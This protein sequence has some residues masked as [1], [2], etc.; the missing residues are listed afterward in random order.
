MQKQV[1]S[2]FDRE[3]G[4][5]LGTRS[6]I[7]VAVKFSADV[8]VVPGHFTSEHYLDVKAMDRAAR[9]GITDP[10]DHIVE[11]PRTVPTVKAHEVNV[12]AGKIIRSRYPLEKQ[13]NIIREGGTA[14]KVMSEFIDG[15]RARSNKI[16]AMPSIPANFVE[17]LNGDGWQ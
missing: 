11:S 14:L 17:L 1:Y 4:K 5:F 3:T 8:I 2:R 10:L 12:A 7:G 15:V 9:A 16:Q 6:A 13:L